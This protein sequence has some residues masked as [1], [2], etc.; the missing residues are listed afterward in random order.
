MCDKIDFMRRDVERGGVSSEAVWIAG[1][2]IIDM[3]MPHI[4]E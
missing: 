3:K 2:M 1:N 4:G